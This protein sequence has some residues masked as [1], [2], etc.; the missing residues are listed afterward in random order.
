MPYRL[1]RSSRHC[2]SSLASQTSVHVCGMQYLHSLRLRHLGSYW[3]FPARQPPE[4]NHSLQGN[5][6][7]GVHLKLHSRLRSLRP[8]R[9]NL[10]SLQR[11]GHPP[12]ASHNLPFLQVRHLLPTQASRKTVHVRGNIRCTY[13]CLRQST[14]S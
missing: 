14:E 4:T 3:M 1:F 9:E 11:S 8:V 7:T 10:S 6:P 5:L 2:T 12:D 13:P